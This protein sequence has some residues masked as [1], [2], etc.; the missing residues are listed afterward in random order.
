[1]SGIYEALRRADHERHP[2]GDDVLDVALDRDDR[3]LAAVGAML[4]RLETRVESEISLSEDDRFEHYA[5]LEV[6]I[7]ALEDR[8]DDRDRAESGSVAELTEVVE[9]LASEVGQLAGRFD[10][11]LPMLRAELVEAVEHKLS[12]AVIPRPPAR[13]GP[14]AGLR[15]IFA[16]RP[17]KRPSRHDAP[18]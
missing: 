18:R 7:G 5:S 11:Q 6:S 8:L 9:R 12:V 16:P 10:Q 15:R 13:Q 3:D 2:N 17:P 1:M 14:L 4:Q